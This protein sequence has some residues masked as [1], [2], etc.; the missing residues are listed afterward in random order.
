VVRPADAVE[1]AAAWAI[2]LGR[3]KAPTAFSLSR[4]KLPNI[5]R[6]DGFD[7][8]TVLRGAYVAQEATGGAPDIVFIATG[9]EVQLAIGAR[10]RLEKAGKKVRV[11]SAPCVDV[12]EEQ[13]QAYR[14]SVLPPG[15]RRV[16]IEAGITDPWRRW[17]GDQGLAIGIDRYGASA[18]DKVIAQKLGLTVDAV[19]ERVNAWL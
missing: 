17:I 2:A 18:P 5:K 6:P 3:K 4:Q 19:V 12:F 14:D 7:P 8:K 13:D 16:S 1:T 9:S 11:V 15:T 10:E